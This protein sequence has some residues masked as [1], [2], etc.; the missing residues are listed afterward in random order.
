MSTTQEN[1]TAIRAIHG[2]IKPSGP[3]GG[4]Q[5]AYRQDVGL[6][7]AERDRLAAVLAEIMPCIPSPAARDVLRHIAAVRLAVE[8]GPGSDAEMDARDAWAGAEHDWRKEGYAVPAE[9]QP[10]VLLA[11]AAAALRGES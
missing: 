8:G 6:L 11:K 9:A 10:G 4:W 2:R 3:G 1:L 7:L 5:E